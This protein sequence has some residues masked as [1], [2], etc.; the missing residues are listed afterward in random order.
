MVS[1]KKLSYE[2]ILDELEEARTIAVR[3][4]SPTA[5]ISASLGKA[6]VLALL[7][8]K[9]KSKSGNDEAYKQIMVEFI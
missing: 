7:S 6:K 5:A 4:E 9:N 2:D 8:D 1:K 3:N